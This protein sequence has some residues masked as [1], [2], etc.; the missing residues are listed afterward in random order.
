MISSAESTI[1]VAA[2]GERTEEGAVKPWIVSQ[3]SVGADQR[4]R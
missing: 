1:E 2:H 3:S 4:K